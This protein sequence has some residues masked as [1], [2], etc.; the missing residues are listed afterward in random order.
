MEDIVYRYS[1][2][3]SKC[4]DIAKASTDPEQP[5]ISITIGDRSVLLDHVTA[6]QLANRLS[7][8]ALPQPSAPY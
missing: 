7:E 3:Q 4:I 1:A 6:L 5:L 2:S 8:I